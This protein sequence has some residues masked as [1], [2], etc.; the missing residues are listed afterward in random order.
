MPTARGVYRMTDLAA[1]RAA[2]RN[3]DASSRTMAPAAIS[4]M[5]QP[6][7]V[8]RERRR[9]ATPIERAKKIA[10]LRE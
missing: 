8:V 4:E 3:G 2:C 6:L 10:A 7:A 5:R 9:S 1:P